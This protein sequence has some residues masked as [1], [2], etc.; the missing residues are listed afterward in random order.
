MGLNSSYLNLFF[1]FDELAPAWCSYNEFDF[2]LDRQ[3]QSQKDYI[4][5]KQMEN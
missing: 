4:R 2:R 3:I 5:V 1:G